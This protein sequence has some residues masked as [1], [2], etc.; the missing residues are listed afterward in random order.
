MTRTKV[1]PSRNR[2]ARLTTR[3]L[4]SLKPTTTGQRYI[5]WDDELSGF[6]V[7]VQQTGAITFMVNYRVRGSRNARRVSLGRLG[8]LTID[9]ARTRAR[10]TLLQIADGLDP[11]T[12]R[13]ARTDAPTVQT[14]GAEW[15]KYIATHHKPRT[16]S[17]W[18][19]IWNKHL[20][21][22]LGSS[23]VADVTKAQVTGIHQKLSA[24]PF[25]GNRC[26]EVLSA[27][28]AYA[29]DQGA[30]A[31]DS[32]PAYRVKAYPEPPRRRYLTP[33]E[34]L[35]LGDALTTAE[36]VGLPQAP[37]R[38]RKRKTG[39]TAKHTTK[40]ANTLQPAD[41]FAIG[42]IRFLLLSGWREQEAL[43]LKWDAIDTARQR[44]L[45]ADTK[46][47]E[48]DRALGAAALALLDELPR[49][50]DSPYV[51]PS[52]DGK[53]PL[54]HIRRVWE[55]VRYAAGFEDLRLHD[56]RHSYASAVV[57]GGGSLL[58]V[59]R[60]LGHASA[61]TS[62]RYAHLLTDPITGT[63]D[64]VAAGLATQLRLPATKLAASR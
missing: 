37:K 7:E 16:V 55:N 33:A 28:F 3:L 59:A 22:P 24:T 47:G 31:E 36:R 17:E 12:V 44:V 46:T 23:K 53:A 51:F 15:L 49:I 9:E 6:G 60:L 56:L 27:F 29:I 4:K 62:E 30:R 42:A 1:A 8:S 63:A 32:N 11:L 38:T 39:S 57:S 58:M 20:V 54:R 5:V 19:R 13:Q 41:P 50:K 25:V 48:S 18:T 21:R 64:T 14:L 26:V 35:R 43:R 34:V 52:G 45:L 61:R 2:H 40:K 10:R